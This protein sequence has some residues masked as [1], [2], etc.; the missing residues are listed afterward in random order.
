MNPDWLYDIP[1]KQMDS[2]SDSSSGSMRRHCCFMSL[3]FRQPSEAMP[4]TQNIGCLDR[5]AFDWRQR[6]LSVPYSSVEMH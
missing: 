4:G 6:C 5:P 3:E 2:F 1:R